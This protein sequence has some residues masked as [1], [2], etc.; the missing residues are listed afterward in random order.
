MASIDR[1]SQGKLVVEEVRSV[2]GHYVR[3]LREWR[4]M[5]LKKWETD[6]KPALLARNVC[7]RKV[8]M[9]VFR[10]KWEYYFSYCEAGFATKTLGDVSIIVGRGGAMKLIEDI[11]M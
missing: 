7:M 2:G 8:D 3:A 11:S 4:E 10:R 9:D 1:A 6:I 5:F